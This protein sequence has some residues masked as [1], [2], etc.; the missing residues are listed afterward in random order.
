MYYPYVTERY[1][2]S[3][4]NFLA[5]LHTLVSL[6]LVTSYLLSVC[7]S[8]LYGDPYPTPKPCIHFLGQYVTLSNHLCRCFHGITGT[9]VTASVSPKV[10]GFGIARAIRSLVAPL[11]S[12]QTF[13]FY[14]DFSH[15]AAPS[16]SLASELQ[17]SGVTVVDTASRGRP[18]ASNKMMIGM[19]SIGATSFV[20]DLVQ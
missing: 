10:S 7:E 2:F 4:I 8:N 11:G 3:S 1:C 17:C 16:S 12:I 9:P 20:S 19:C 5:P 18:N 15:P 6:T 13:K 14:V